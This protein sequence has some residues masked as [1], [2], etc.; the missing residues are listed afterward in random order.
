MKLDNEDKLTYVPFD[1]DI[2]EWGRKN[3]KTISPYLTIPKLFQAN[4][5]YENLAISILDKNGQEVMQAKANEEYKI[6]VKIHNLGR[7]EA[8]NV[9]V[10]FRWGNPS[11]SLSEEL[12]QRVGGGTQP[13]VI[14]KVVR[15]TRNMVTGELLEPVEIECPI[16]WKPRFTNG[17]HECLMVMCWALNDPYESLQR[18]QPQIERRCAQRN[19]WPISLPPNSTEKFTI[20]LTNL[21]PLRGFHTVLAAMSHIT[22]APTALLRMKPSEILSG[23]LQASHSSIGSSPNV[24]GDLCESVFSARTFANHTSVFASKPASIRFS[25]KI[26]DSIGLITSAGAHRLLANLLLANQEHSVSIP[27]NFSGMLPLHEV[28]LR[29][30]EIRQMD[31]EVRVPP[32]ARPG[33]FIVYRFEQVSEGM[34]IGGY[35]IV[36]QVEDT[37]GVYAR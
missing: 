23:V 18:W 32:D 2:A 30:F 13:Q 6:S 12:L 27:H 22:A 26:S 24:L 10:D 36:V 4:H 5:W 9:N 17:I 1:T 31:L 14:G 15:L 16:P 25:S 11:M 34:L 21:F 29:P 35:T 19:I 7:L 20:E 37:S 33:D 28:Q 8:F 3:R